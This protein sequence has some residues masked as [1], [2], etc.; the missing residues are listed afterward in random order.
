MRCHFKPATYI[1]LT[2]S[3]MASNFITFVGVNFDWLSIKRNVAKN[4]AWC[5]AFS[6][7]TLGGGPLSTSKES[8]GSALRSKLGGSILCPKAISTNFDM[9]YCSHLPYH[10]ISKWHLILSKLQFWY[11]ECQIFRILR[12]IFIFP[13]DPHFPCFNII[14]HINIFYS[15]VICASYINLRLTMHLYMCGYH[16]ICI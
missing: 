12:S 5:W 15:H 10:I 4:W 14:L 11:E 16:Q 6:S 7:F 1:L 13:V 3:Y 8:K 9:Q 2:F